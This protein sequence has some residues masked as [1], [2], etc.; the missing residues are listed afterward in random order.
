[1]SLNSPDA[2]EIAPTV[3]R[4]LLDVLPLGVFLRD[5]QGRLL[6]V[7]QLAARRFGRSPEDMLG[8]TPHELYAADAAERI[9]ATDRQV[10]KDGQAI[11]RE[12]RHV[13]ADGKLHT[14]FTGKVRVQFADGR[15]GVLG[16]GLDV[17]ARKQAEDAL[18]AQTELLASILD[19]D[20]SYIVLKDAEGRYLMANRAF[21]AWTGRS[22]DTLRE[23]KAQ[24]IARTDGEREQIA[25][26]EALARE[27]GA[28]VTRVEHYI[29][30]DG[31]ESIVEATR[32]PMKDALGREQML[33]VSRDV[34]AARRREA[35][36]ETARQRADQAN[37]AKD[38]F[39]ANMSH[40]LRT[41]MHGVL[42]S[43][44][45]LS[46]MDLSD[47][48]RRLI[49]IARRSGEHLLGVID[50]VLDYSKIEAGGLTLDEQAVD[51]AGLTQE[52]V[53]SLALIAQGK[54]IDVRAEID[55]ALPSLILADAQRLR[56]VFINLLGNALKFTE[57]GEICLALRAEAG[58]VHC[59]VRDTGI[60]MTDEQMARIFEPFVQADDSI[61]KRFGGT[62]LGLTITRR[63]LQAMGSDLQVQ[64]VPGEGA[65]F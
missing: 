1:M 29:R 13:L 51:L 64:S 7:N 4:M 45:L 8:K 6:L 24:E 31:S 21:Q 49:D 54:G 40:E 2:A 46:G 10:L 43:L 52:V 9:L 5:E 28:A 48:Q 17:T 16:F 14:M 57:R 12:E 26:H 60:G 59:S 42:G 63:L 27:S 55:R 11:E 39:L 33:V 3:L 36:L 38:A 50:D 41:P 25:A 30:L 19:A 20:P 32:I 47:E 62:G 58:R 53:Q 44:A 65:C 34:T 37:R 18:R 61:G 23:L 15:F 56:Q 35:E 22:L